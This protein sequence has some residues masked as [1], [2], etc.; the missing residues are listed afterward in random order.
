MSNYPGG[1]DN[2]TRRVDNQDTILAND[3]NELQE[4]I[5]NIE[6]ELGTDPAGSFDD[7]KSRLDDIDDQLDNV[8]VEDTNVNLSGGNVGGHDTLEEHVKDV[9]IHGD[10]EALAY[11]FPQMLDRT[12]DQLLRGVL[13]SG[14]PLNTA[15]VDTASAYPLD[16][17]DV[18]FCHTLA[19]PSNSGYGF[20][21]VTNSS[22]SL[23]SGGGLRL[24]NEEGDP[25]FAD[26]SWITRF[27]PIESFPY[28][29]SEGFEIETGCLVSPIPWLIR[30]IHPMVGS[31][32]PLKLQPAAK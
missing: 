2:F 17:G 22:S 26:G 16:K 19:N 25:V 7:V 14:N 23:A 21:M 18:V 4:A 28:D 15:S 12:M 11:N 3:V 10:L 13:T 8:T 6:A 5:E 20:L 1:I 30:Q 31:W 9:N 24:N 29:E 32:P 27:E